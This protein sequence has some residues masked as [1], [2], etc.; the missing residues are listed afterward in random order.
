MRH[1]YCLGSHDLENLKESDISRLMVG[2]DVVLKI[3]KEAPEL[4]ESILNI[5]NLL[6]HDHAGQTELDIPKLQ[7]K[8][9]EVVGIAGIEGNGQNTLSDVLVGMKSYSNG[10]VE[11]NRK[12][13]HKK[14]T[15][16]IRLMGLAYIPEDRMDFGCAP[17]MS[18]KDNIISDRYYKKEFRNGIFLNR[19]KV[20]QLADQC[21]QDFEIACDNRDQ[22]VR[23]LSGGNIQK[24]VVA[25][26][27][28]S[29]ANFIL[30]NQPTRGIDVGAA[31]MIRKA[32]VQKS[33]TEGV[34]TLLISAD[35]NEILECTDRLLV[36]RKGKIVAAF[37]ETSKVTEEELGEYMLGLKEMSMKEM[38][39]VL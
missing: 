11:L 3:E 32:I 26:E 21:I 12:D 16:E 28:T 31:Q 6:I 14:T 33:R 15:H 10:K 20:N 4:G 38:E 39:G 23:M 29:G 8:K 5:E 17:D 30:A 18:I 35:L 2:R 7:V 36:M 27:F 24:V 34:A 19:K 25:R 1:G 9:G 22:P 37:P 13:I